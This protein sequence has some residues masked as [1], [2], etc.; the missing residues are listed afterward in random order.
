[1]CIR[2]RYV[3]MVLCYLRLDSSS[4]DYVIQ[5]YDLDGIVRQA[6]RKYASQF[7]DVY[8]R[9]EQSSGVYTMRNFSACELAV[10][11]V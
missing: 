5:K 1:M 3:E 4:T 10:E 9:Q 6:V 11:G 2:D 7:I 8:K